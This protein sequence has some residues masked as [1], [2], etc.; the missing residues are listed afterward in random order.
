VKLRAQSASRRFGVPGARFARSVAS[1]THE[2][3]RVYVVLLNDYYWWDET[4]A[5]FNYAFNNYQWPE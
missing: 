4:A 5:L 2:G 1:A 3:H